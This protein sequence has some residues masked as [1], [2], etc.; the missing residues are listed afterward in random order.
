MN[1]L[2]RWYFE[3]HLL[4]SVILPQEGRYG[5]LSSH[6]SAISSG[7]RFLLIGFV[8]VIV[9]CCNRSFV[10]VRRKSATL[11]SRTFLPYLVFSL[12]ALFFHFTF[13]YCISSFFFFFSF[14]LIFPTFYFF[15]CKLDIQ[16]PCRCWNFNP[17]GTW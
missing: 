14:L 12:Q 13:I 10:H 1:V 11:Q 7:V 8:F 2:R 15:F 5:R 4:S 3:Y 6:A 16:C 9:F 17:R